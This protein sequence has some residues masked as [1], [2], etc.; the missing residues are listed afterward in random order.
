MARTIYKRGLSDITVIYPRHSNTMVHVVHSRCTVWTIH[1]PTCITLT[2][3]SA[4]HHLSRSILILPN[5]M[6]DH[7]LGRLAACFHSSQTLVPVRIAPILWMVDV[8]DIFV[9]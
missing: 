9:V 8:T 5:Q 1:L 2:V 3:V 7:L 6:E 4:H